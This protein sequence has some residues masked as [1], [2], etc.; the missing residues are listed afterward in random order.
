MSTDASTRAIPV[1]LSGLIDN[2]FS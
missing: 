1:R 2:N